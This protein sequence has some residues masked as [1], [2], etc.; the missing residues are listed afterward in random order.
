MYK[1]QWLLKSLSIVVTKYKNHIIN[2]L[3][4]LKYAFLCYFSNVLSQTTHTL[5]LQ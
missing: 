3:K 2:K 4:G 1:F 5:K